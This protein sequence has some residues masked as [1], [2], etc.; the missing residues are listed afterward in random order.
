MINRLV[1]ISS[2]IV[3]G[4]VIATP[5]FAQNWANWRGPEQ[6]G[7]SRETNLPDNWS[8]EPK[9]NV[10]WESDI[11]GRATPII[12]NGR[13]YLNTRTHHDFTDPV[14]KV[15]AREQV[16]CWDLKTGDVLWK[17]EFNVFH[18][19]IPSPRVGWAAMCGDEETGN[20]FVHSVSG[21]FRCYSPDGKIVWEK[22][23]LE[24]FG[25][26]SGYGGRTQTPIIDEDRVIVSFLAANWGETKGPGPKHYYYAFDKKNG[27]LQW[28]SA[29]GGAPQDTNYSVPIV[30]VINGQR[31]LIGGNSDGGIYGINARTGTPI[32]GF[33]MS[34]RGL[35]SSPVVDG[36]LVYISHG[37]DNIDNNDFGR[38]QCIDASETGDLTETGSVW[39]HDGLKAG[40]TALLVK[41]GVLYV[42][43]DTGN[44]NAFDGKS[45]EKLW[46]HNLGTVGKGSPVWADGKMYVM[47]VNGNIHILEANREGCKQLSLVQLKATTVAGL[48]EIY[49]SPAISEG[50][51]V[52]VTR[53]RT[54]CIADET[55]KPGMN[56]IPS[57]SA[58]KDAVE[59]VALVQ[60]RPYEVI[61]SPGEK[62]QFSLHAFDANG[63]L[64][65]QIT[66][67]IITIGE[68]LDSLKSENGAIWADP[69]SKD[70]AG[71]IS[72]SMFGK[73]ATARVRMFNADKTWSWDFEGYKGVRVPPTWLR[74]HVK[75]KPVDVDGNTVM[76]AAGMGKGKGRPSH[77]VFIGTPNMKDYTISADVMMKEQNRQMPSIGL[78]ANRYNFMIKGNNGKLAIQSWAPHLRMA[79]VVRF[80]SDPDVWYTMKM[81]VEV[82][83]GEATVF[84]KV[85]KRGDEEPEAW[86]LTQTDPHPN[87]SGSP[88][89]YVYAQADC[90]FDNV[91]VQFDDQAVSHQ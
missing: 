23:L 42:V 86:T 31:Q 67:P 59:K 2:L 85:W 30:A 49:A 37:E 61:L 8:L 84:G 5:A 6:N 25:K 45:G 12:L 27:D 69:V 32:W 36:N 16:V 54:I 56:E 44:L 81:R 48:D 64:I 88:G 50:H 65:K 33:R 62:V 57:M 28:V 60:L 4:L 13:V 74:A 52:F 75:L 40:Y 10:A 63:R 21:E 73:T 35:N 53:D 41:D 29:P 15:H 91:V 11:G 39:R 43:S 71:T 17:D 55:K 90:L 80:R 38:I 70:I 47:E 58:E 76:R 87:E 82:A 46:E 34:R 19:D 18:T 22:S 24:E 7:I 51:I 72:T 83:D 9:K 20:V 66:N 78:I 79:K 14:E 77:M 1:R 68:G 89:L 26:I 3:L